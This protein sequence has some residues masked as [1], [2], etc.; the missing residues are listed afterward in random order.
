[1]PKDR[2]PPFADVRAELEHSVWV[3]VLIGR[4]RASSVSIY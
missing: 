4:N 1:M 2:F 3:I